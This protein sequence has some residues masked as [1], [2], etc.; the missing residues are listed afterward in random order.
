MDDHTVGRTSEIGGVTVR[1]LHH[2]DS[3]GLLR[4]SG[5]SRAGYRHYS[6]A[7]LERLRE[8]RLYRELGLSL[9]QIA[10]MLD[11]PDADP[12]VQLRRQRD[13]LNARI[14]RLRHMVRALER[15]MEAK[16]MDIDLSPEERFEIFG[17]FVP[18][19]HQAEA[20]ERWG[21]TD[22]YTQ[23]QKRVSA[24]GKKQW[25]EIKAEAED[26]NRRFATALTSGASP[27]SDE[28]M[29][30]AEAHRS[31]ITKWFYDCSFEI[32]SGL[33]DMYVADPRFKA[34]YDDQVEGLA[35]FVAAAIK[36]NVARAHS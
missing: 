27:Q 28:V 17:D 22:A 12:S 16:Q 6:G 14:A 18:E 31:H 36:S 7:D 25:T 21:G 20:E 3:I 19:D 29:E 30:I 15:E 26:I 1:T 11:D 2:Y 32:H 5:R 34:S 23:S 4:P 24:Y 9:E 33:A 35:E 10:E 8:I 13:L